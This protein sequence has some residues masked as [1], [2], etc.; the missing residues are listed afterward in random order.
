[1]FQDF[2]DFYL[3]WDITYFETPFSLQS[4]TPTLSCKMKLV[5]ACF[6]VLF[7]FYNALCFLAF[8]RFS[9]ASVRWEMWFLIPT[10][11]KLSLTISLFFFDLPAWQSCQKS[12]LADY[13]LYF[14]WSNLRN[15]RTS[16]SHSFKIN[17]MKKFLCLFSKKTALKVLR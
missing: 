15:K 1:M 5:L 8:F 9:D 6:F 13:S 14:I 11:D 2:P 12:K 4:S 3:K 16:S 10:G 7:L 17:F